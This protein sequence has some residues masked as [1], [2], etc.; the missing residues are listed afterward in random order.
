MKRL[1]IVIL[2]LT[3][4]Y[5]CQAQ[6]TLKEKQETT[7]EMQNTTSD[8]STDG[9]DVETTT[10]EPSTETEN[11]SFLITVAV[12][13][14]NVRA[15]PDL[16]GEVLG[17]IHLNDS[18][19]VYGQV[20]TKAY[21]W[22][23]IE[24]DDQTA[25]IASDFCFD[26]RKDQKKA[27]QYED[28]VMTTLSVVN[29]EDLFEIGSSDMYQFKEN[30]LK[31]WVRYLYDEKEVWCLEEIN[32]LSFELA[33]KP[34]VLL[35]ADGEIDFTETYDRLNIASYEQ[36]TR[37]SAF[38]EDGEDQK[39]IH[40]CYSP[41]LDEIVAAGEFLEVSSEKN[42]VLT[43][44]YSDNAKAL[45]FTVHEIETGELLYQREPFTIVTTNGVSPITSFA[46]DKIGIHR[47]DTTRDDWHR[48]GPK[49]VEIS[50]II[51]LAE[52]HVAPRQ[53]ED[54]NETLFLETYLSP[55]ESAVIGERQVESID[56]KFTD[57]IDY[58]HQGHLLWFSYTEGGQT[59]YVSRPATKADT[60]VIDQEHP[61]TLILENETAMA[62]GE[63]EQTYLMLIRMPNE[64]VAPFSVM[65]DVDDTTYYVDLMA[66]EKAVGDSFYTSPS[67]SF[68]LHYEGM[69]QYDNFIF[70]LSD[71][72]MGEVVYELK[73]NALK[74]DFNDLPLFKDIQWLNDQAVQMTLV[75]TKDGEN[76]ETEMI[77]YQ[78]GDKWQFTELETYKSDH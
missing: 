50:E 6:N 25:Y 3:M 19:K 18:V 34:F 56:L 55:F 52:K 4:L 36:Y 59:Y 73:Y 26:K 2:C 64:T 61:V 48:I 60:I 20:E 74:L 70:E 39:G 58:R 27:Y 11:D 57:I 69:D 10:E 29:T 14:L 49:S 28:N 45:N 72:R 35:T 8:D 13:N 62:F 15:T 63:G 22:Y 75:N 77:L 9:K 40:Y 16:E 17:Q 23:E 21:D 71:V 30:K 47:Y 44:D 65:F 53:I 66:G 5:S 43:F 37:L 67:S 41:V 76:I 51:D 31:Q 32:Q 68:Q 1:G 24:Y 7:Q 46:K 54:V 12:D 33:E 42:M 38:K 78:E